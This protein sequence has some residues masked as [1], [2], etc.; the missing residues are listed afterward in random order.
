MVEERSQTGTRL[1]N[2]M[3]IT[4]SSLPSR[5]MT[6]SRKAWTPERYSARW[7]TLAALRTC[8]N[9]RGPS[10][11]LNPRRTVF[12]GDWEGT[13]A[14]TPILSRSGREF[15]QTKFRAFGP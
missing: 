13:P 6:P 2:G 15:P 11:R 12:G 14:L 10:I 3:G 8:Q 1:T 7:M 9:R 4:R 5:V